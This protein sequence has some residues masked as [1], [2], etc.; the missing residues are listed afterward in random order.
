MGKGLILAQQRRAS[1]C[2]GKPIR[3]VRRV[4]CNA[5]AALEHRE[6]CGLHADLDGADAGQRWLIRPGSPWVAR[7]DHDTS[8]RLHEHRVSQQESLMKASYARFAA[9]IVTGTVLMYGLMYLNT[10][11]LA[12]VRWSETRAYMALIM[13]AS[14]AI[15][16]LAFMLGM[17]EN[18]VANIAI[19]ASAALLFAG[20]LYMVRSQATVDEV[21]WMRAMIPHHSI[22]ILTSERANITDPRAR[23][24][25][26]EIIETQRREIAE[27][28]QLIAE[29]ERR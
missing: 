8:G 9:M 10:H 26:D 25:A 28:E 20:S 5:V 4:S 23:E 29:L 22:A 11:E 14:M 12:H 3:P 19:F 24:L 16:M 17:Y 13:G 27:M 18:R 6:R 15:V 1:L 21:S 7:L 2:A